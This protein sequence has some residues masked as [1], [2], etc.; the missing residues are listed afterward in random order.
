VIVQA[1]DWQVTPGSMT[2]VLGPSGCGKSTL[3]RA[4]LGIWPWVSGKVSVNGEVVG[5]LSAALGGARVGYLPQAVELFD[6]TIAENIARMGEVDAEAV[7]RAAQAAGLHEWV[8]RQAQGY[9]TPIGESGQLLSGGQRQRIGLA[10][11]LYG[12]PL[13]LVLDEP[14]AH[15]DEAGEQALNQTLRAALERGQQVLVVSHRPGVLALATHVLLMQDGR[16]VW[17]G[18]K[19]Q[20]QAMLASD[21]VNYGG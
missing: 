13:W 16:M 1:V 4:M 14:N 21:G 2:A 7:I 9:D 6:G 20:A 3:L 8:L 15:L 18:P 17:S 5:G 10:R 11:A 12:D 19:T